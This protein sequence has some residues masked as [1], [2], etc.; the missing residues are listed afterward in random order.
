M[1]Q[2]SSYSIMGASIKCFNEKCCMDERNVCNME[3][4]CVKRMKILSE[5]ACR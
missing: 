5:D 1:G 4:L 3:G 2:Y